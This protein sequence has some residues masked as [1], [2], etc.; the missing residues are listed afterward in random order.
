MMYGAISEATPPQNTKITLTF[1]KQGELVGCVLYF[2]VSHEGQTVGSVNYA[3][4]FSNLNGSV[5]ISAPANTSSFEEGDCTERYQT[6]LTY[7]N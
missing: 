7:W 5:T 3:L 2:D 6:F 4:N 1:T